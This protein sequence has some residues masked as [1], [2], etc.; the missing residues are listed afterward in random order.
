L[1]TTVRFLKK[2]RMKIM[3]LQKKAKVVAAK[4]AVVKKVVAKKVAP[5]K[6][7]ARRER[8]IKIIEI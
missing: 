6:V 8:R 7:G 3:L 1:L 2:K 5:K 4:E